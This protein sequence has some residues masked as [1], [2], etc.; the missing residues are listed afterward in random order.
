[1]SYIKVTEAGT[2]AVK[3]FMETLDMEYN[4]DN[5]EKVINDILGAYIYRSFKFRTIKNSLKRDQSTERKIA[6][7]DKKLVE[8]YEEEM[9]INPN[10]DWDFI[11]IS[12]T[13]RFIKENTK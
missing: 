3:S 7:I 10:I 5:E 4:K 13:K 1:M 2:K 8:N 12:L 9:S 6:K 11:L